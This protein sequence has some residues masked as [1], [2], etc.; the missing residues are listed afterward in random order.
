MPLGSR[1]GGISKGSAF[2]AP[3]GEPRDEL[4]EDA[5][6]LIVQYQNASASFLQRKMSIGYARAARILDE[7][8]QAGIIGPTDGAKPRDILVTDVNSYL[9][10]QTTSG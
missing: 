8:H 3:N 5:F 7:L 1:K 4:F 10:N 9:S 2:I 6:R